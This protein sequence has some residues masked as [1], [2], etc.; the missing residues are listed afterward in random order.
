[1]SELLSDEVPTEPGDYR[2]SGDRVNRSV[3]RILDVK[4]AGEETG[5]LWTQ[6]LYGSM[7]LEVFC[8]RCKPLFSPRIPDPEQLAAMQDAIDSV[9]QEWR[10]HHQIDDPEWEGYETMQKINKLA[11]KTTE[12]TP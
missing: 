3:V 1:M 9:W 11:T 10:N 2:F 7:R 5:T 8:Q 12:V 6:S 4:E